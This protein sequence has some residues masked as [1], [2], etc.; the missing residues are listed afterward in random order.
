MVY[1]T[2]CGSENADGTRFCTKCGATLNM[3]A[4]ESGRGSSGGLGDAASSSPPSSSSGQAADSGPLG[5]ETIYS[6]PSSS[7]T[8]ESGSSY[9]PYATPNDPYGSSPYGAQP[10]S[11]PGGSSSYAD[12]AYSSG[13]GAPYSM[14]QM[15]QGGGGGLFAIG[16][17]RDP[18]MIIVFGLL[19][20]GIYMLYW[21]Y[22][23][24]TESKNA[25]GREDINPAMELVLALVTC[26]I[27]GIYLYYKYP[28]LFLDMQQRVGLPQNDMSTLCLVLAFCGPLGLLVPYLIQ[29]ELNKI[30]DAAGAR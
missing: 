9:N 1:C 14:Q 26:G 8:S 11:T 16:E 6:P 2:S 29:T 25:L 13:G 18:V 12:P 17:K 20:C 30:W 28:K 15:G 21:W 19:T 3:S 22:M 7:A 23:I 24:I 10:S 4:A 27:Y 5:A